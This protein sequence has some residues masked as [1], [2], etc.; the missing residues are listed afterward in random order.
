MDLLSNPLPK[1]TYVRVNAMTTS[2]CFKD[3]TAVITPYLTGIVLPKVEAARELQTIDW[4]VA[5][6]EEERGLA[7]GSVEIVPIIET[8]KGI[9]AVNEIARAAPRVRHMAFGMV[10]LAADMQLDLGDDH[11]AIAHARFAVAVASRAAGLQGPLDTA[12]VDIKNL[13]RLRRTASHARSMGYVGKGCI[14]PDQIAVV[15]E[16]F[17]PTA[18]EIERATKIIAAFAAAEASG[19]AAISVDGMMIDYPV[20]TWAQHVM[21][22]QESLD[23]P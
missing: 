15:N 9:A 17:S 6:L 5:Q 19:A 11:G 7:P 4:L 12:F 14:H 18:A 20:V 8:A 16:V 23:K 13:E 22:F 2:H 10:D 1:S 21:A 3:I